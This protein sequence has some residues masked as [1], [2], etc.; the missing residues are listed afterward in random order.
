M[1]STI[2]KAGI[3]N[4]EDVL[5]AHNH[6]ASNV[7]EESC[8]SYLPFQ[9]RNMNVCGL[10][11]LLSCILLSEK[12]YL[13]MLL[14]KKSLPADLSW[15]QQIDQFD[16]FVRKYFIYCF[17]SKQIDRSII[18]VESEEV[19]L[20]NLDAV[21]NFS[22]DGDAFRANVDTCKDIGNNDF[23]FHVDATNLDTDPSEG[24]DLLHELNNHMLSEGVD[25]GEDTNKE[26]NND[27]TGFKLEQTF[28]S[29]LQLKQA[30]K[31]YEQRVL[32][33]SRLQR[34]QYLNA[35][36]MQIPLYVTTG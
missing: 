26:T 4:Q 28:E 1:F 29:Y 16:E 11:C 14:N 22:N 5:L 7:C 21:A 27:I 20:C 12:D 2:N 15:L 10:A 6:G 35:L 13:E 8:L 24:V 33:P 3:R 9:G 17:V 34:R 23:L 32:S 19:T 36:R 30:I 18:R 25:T 31:Q